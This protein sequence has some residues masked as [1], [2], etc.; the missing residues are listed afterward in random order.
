MPC[1]YHTHNCQAQFSGHFLRTDSICSLFFSDEETETLR[2]CSASKT[3][4]LLVGGRNGFGPWVIWGQSP[5]CD[6]SITISWGTDGLCRGRFWTPEDSGGLCRNL[7]I[8]NTSVSEA[9]QVHG[10]TE[11]EDCLQSVLAVARC[12]SFVLPWRNIWYS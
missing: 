5:V 4:R 10:E 2:G 3:L 12:Y 7:T 9:Y 11:T 1:I 6:P 8:T